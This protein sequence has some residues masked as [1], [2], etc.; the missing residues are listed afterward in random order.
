MW[1]TFVKSTGFPISM[2]ADHSRKEI[3]HFFF[4]KRDDSLWKNPFLLFSC[5]FS[6]LCWF[7]VREHRSF[8]RTSCSSDLIP[9]P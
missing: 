3:L 8:P 6:L 9:N 7:Y 2:A 1:R 5:P 4:W